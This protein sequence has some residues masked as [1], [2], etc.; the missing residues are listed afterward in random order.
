MR[1][2]S[3]IIRRGRGILTLCFMMIRSERGEGGWGLGGGGRC[4]AFG[5]WDSSG[6]ILGGMELGDGMGGLYPAHGL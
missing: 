3:G 6:S 1:I 5:V 4:M 2:S